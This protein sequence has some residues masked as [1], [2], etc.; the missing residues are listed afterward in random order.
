MANNRFT[1]YTTL[2]DRKCE[3]RRLREK[4]SHTMTESYDMCPWDNE[5]V[6]EG[7]RRGDRKSRRRGP[8]RSRRRL[9]EQTHA[10]KHSYCSQSEPRRREGAL[11][12]KALLALYQRLRLEPASMSSLRTDRQAIAANTPQLLNAS[13]LR[14]NITRP[15]CKFPRPE[16]PVAGFPALFL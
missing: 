15:G 14:T 12:S 4:M 2:K 8:S 11:F 7:R 10:H 13:E 16:A 9:S 1:Q 3:I 6:S 5:C